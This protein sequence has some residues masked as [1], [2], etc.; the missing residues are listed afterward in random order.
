MAGSAPGG[1]DRFIQVF[2]D[3]VVIDQYLPATLHAMGVT[4]WLGAVTIIC[5]LALG[6]A[7]ACLRALGNRWLN[8]PIVLFADILRALPPLVLLLLLYFGLPSLGIM[9][10]GTMVLFL[11]LTAVL[12]AFSEEIFWAG[13]TSLPKGQWEAGSATGLSFGQV[14]LNI[15]LPQAFRLAVPS[16]V[17]RSLAITKMTA[18]GSVIGVKEILSVSS[19]AQAMSGSATPLTMAAVAYLVIFLPAVLVARL[20]ERRLSWKV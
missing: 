10:P 3:P 1:L 14:L 17:N 2:F 19:S 16:L 18:L 8:I 13:L 11:V 15:A 6:L 5:G 20:L 7:L 4:L 12:A 9:M